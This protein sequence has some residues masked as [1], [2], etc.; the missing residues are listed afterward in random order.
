M[1]KH[2]AIARAE[3]LLARAVAT[4]GI[5]Q[6]YREALAALLPLARRNAPPQTES[7]AELAR[8]RDEARACARVLAHAYTTD[9]GPPAQLVEQA[10]AYPVIPE[11]P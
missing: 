3:D 1:I 8:D 5:A 6:E 10:L 2:P 11:T 4:R 7:N 9:N